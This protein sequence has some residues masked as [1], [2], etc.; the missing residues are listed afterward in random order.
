KYTIYGP[1][2][3]EPNHLI[4]LMFAVTTTAA[5]KETSTVRQLITYTLCGLFVFGVSLSPFA[6]GLSDPSSNAGPGR[7]ELNIGR[8]S[9]VQSETSPDS[10]QRIRSRSEFDAVSRTYYGGRLYALPHVMF[11]I[12]RRDHD[13]TY[14]I[15]S[16]RYRFHKDF[17]N[18]SY[19]SL[20]RGNVFYENN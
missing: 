12:D 3:Q 17:I 9:A 18:A 11:A 16:S 19:L 10:L 20:E 5:E 13:K 6:L 8:H 4:G 14:Y 1:G 7:L 15:N 2:F